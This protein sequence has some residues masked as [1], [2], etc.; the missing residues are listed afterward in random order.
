MRFPVV[1]QVTETCIA[2][3][4]MHMK[5]SLG[6]NHITCHECNLHSHHMMNVVI[7]Q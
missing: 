4:N 2:A 6:Y 1:T 3:R 5:D 7:S